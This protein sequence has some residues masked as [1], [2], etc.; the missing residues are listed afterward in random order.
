M[1]VSVVRGERDVCFECIACP[2]GVVIDHPPRH[3]GSYNHV[4]RPMPASRLVCG[5]QVF[6][7]RKHVK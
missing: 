6:Q 1:A 4:D 5:L 3:A 7:R 2:T